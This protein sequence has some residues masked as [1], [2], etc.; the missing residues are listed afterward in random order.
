M[1]KIKKLKK[2]LYYDDYGGLDHEKNEHWF[3]RRWFYGKS[4]HGSIFKH[5]KTF[6]QMH[7]LSLYLKQYATLFLNRRGF[8]RKIWI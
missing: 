6:L 3:S 1:I 7:H 4:T 2:Y 5:A 8:Q